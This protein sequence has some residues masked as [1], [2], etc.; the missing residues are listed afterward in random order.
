MAVP[1]SEWKCDLC[2][3]ECI[4]PEMNGLH[5]TYI[6]VERFAGLNVCG[7]SLIKVFAEILCIALARSTCYLV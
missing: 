7:F 1:V 6:D 3:G 2:S 5:E 4:Q